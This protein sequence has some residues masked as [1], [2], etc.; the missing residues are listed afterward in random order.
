MQ[1]ALGMH[2][3]A[4]RHLMELSMLVVLRATHGLVGFTAYVVCNVEGVRSRRF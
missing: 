3:F 4:G 2:Q 1:P